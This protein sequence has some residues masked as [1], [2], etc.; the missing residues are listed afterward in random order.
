ML[1]FERLGPS[2]RSDEYGWREQ[3]LWR[4]RRL[5]LVRRCAERTKPD[6]IIMGIDFPILFFLFWAL[7]SSAS[8]RW[9]LLFSLMMM[10]CV[11]KREIQVQVT[12]IYY[13]CTVLGFLASRFSRLTRLTRLSTS[14]SVDLP[15]NSSATAALADPSCPFYFPCTY[16]CTS[17]RTHIQISIS[18]LY[19]SLYI[20][21][22]VEYN[23]ITA[24]LP[25]VIIVSP[26]QRSR[27]DR[28][29]HLFKHL[30]QL[31]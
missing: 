27:D 23:N 3:E 18:P 6:S 11:W 10:M 7:C 1:G 30:F 8:C 26:G 29:Q 13:D 15:L 25:K 20:I 19:G 22:R 28:C 24:I 16:I 2:P 14:T 12:Y 4:R 17:T 31:T 9:V 21:C 5:G